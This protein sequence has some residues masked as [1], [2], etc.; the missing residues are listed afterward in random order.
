M[1]VILTVTADALVRLNNKSKQKDNKSKRLTGEP[2]GVQT[3]H[4]ATL[5]AHVRHRGGGARRQ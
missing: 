4:I 5:Q 1:S 2:R 3:E